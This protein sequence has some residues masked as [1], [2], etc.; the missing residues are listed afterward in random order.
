MN[1]MKQLEKLME[2]N[3]D[4]LIRLKNGENPPLCPLD[5]WDCPYY[6]DNGY[7]TIGNPAEECETYW[8]FNSD[9][10]EEEE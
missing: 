9:E 3:K 8:F 1:A 10:E 5:E 7:C 6:Q 4:V 2:E